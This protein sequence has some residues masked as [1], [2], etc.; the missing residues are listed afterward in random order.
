MLW[1][2]KLETSIVWAKP[3]LSFELRF[4]WGT[5]NVMPSFKDCCW[6]S[7]HW[8]II[9]RLGQLLAATLPSSSA[10][11]YE[12]NFPLTIPDLQT[13]LFRTKSPLEVDRTLYLIYIRNRIL[14]IIANTLAHSSPSNNL[15]FVSYL[16]LSAVSPVSAVKLVL[17]SGGACSRLVLVEWWGCF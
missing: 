6:M 14:N 1:M 17:A 4:L 3:F 16:L 9:Y 11:Q 13:A 7:A 2:G 12:A 5:V 10:D 8:H 15:Q